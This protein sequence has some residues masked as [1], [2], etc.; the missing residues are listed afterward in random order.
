MAKEIIFRYE[1]YFLF[2]GLT[3]R[4]RWRCGLTAK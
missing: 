2:G 1:G 3:P 4:K